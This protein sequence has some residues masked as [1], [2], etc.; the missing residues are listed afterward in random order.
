MLNAASEVDWDEAVG[1][2]CVSKS[3]THDRLIV[4]P[5]VSNS[6]CRTI[7]QYSKSLAHGCLLTLLSLDRDFGFRCS[8]DDLSDYY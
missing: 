2:F 6:R 5:T 3:A 1:L 7:S 4:N 8:T